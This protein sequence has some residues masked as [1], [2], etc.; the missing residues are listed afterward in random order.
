VVAVAPARALAPPV[1]VAVPVAPPAPAPDPE[2]WY[3]EWLAPG[4]KRALLRRLDNRAEAT[5]QTRVV[6][7]DTGATVVDETF[8]ELGKI[9]FATI[10]R[11]TTEAA[12]LEGLLAAPAFGDDL[13]RGAKLA[14][15]FPFGSCGR[16]SASK[17]AIAFNA[18]DW[19]YVADKVGKIRKRVSEEAA[20]DP[21]FTPDGQH[22]LFRRASA[23][24]HGRAK[25]E[26]YAVPSDLS[27]PPRVLAGTAGARDRFIIDEEGRAAVAVASQEPQVKTCVLSIGLRPPFATRKVACLDGGEPLLESVISP[28]GR[29]VATTTQVTRDGVHSWRLRA[30]SVRTGKVALDVPAASGMMLRAISDT[31]LLVQSGFGGA[32]VDDL[33]AKTRR[34]ID[35]PLELG[36][37][38]FF[39]G[40]SE[41]VVV[42]GGAVG[43]VDIAKE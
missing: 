25:Y 31:G 24:E 41:L 36:H 21:R 42:R 33:A 10:G 34:V 15:G 16:L 9:P 27:A 17:S 40:P 43:V 30:I 32:I 28:K 14:G 13:V 8:L 29:W 19:L 35:H 22:L 7:V 38:G 6:D 23:V 4:G 1:A 26:L 5:L 18:G 3:F 11:K 39:R 12:G 37:R 2:H 20:Y